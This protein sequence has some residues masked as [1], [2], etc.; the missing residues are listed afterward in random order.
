M[1]EC[2]HKWIYQEKQ[3]KTNVT[4][5]ENYTAHYHRVDLYFCENCCEIKKVEEKQNVDLPFGGVRNLPAYAPIWY[6]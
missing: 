1:D 6:Q 5:Y 3:L 4:G 2:K